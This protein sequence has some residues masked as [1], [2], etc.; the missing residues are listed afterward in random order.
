MKENEEES[1]GISRGQQGQHPAVGTTVFGMDPWPNPCAR[2][3]NHSSA[4]G[5]FGKGLAELSSAQLLGAHPKGSITPQSSLLIPA[6][7]QLGDEGVW[8]W[9]QHLR[10]A[11]LGE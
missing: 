3:R 1:Q 2:A 7:K 6:Q 5:W 11:G 9:E 10:E 4:Q 8:V